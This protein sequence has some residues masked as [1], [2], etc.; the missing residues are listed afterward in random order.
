MAEET[1]HTN[2][3][4]PVLAVRVTKI[5]WILCII[6]TFLAWSV[7]GFTDHV[8]SIVVAR[9]EKL[10]EIVDHEMDD[11]NDNYEKSFNLLLQN[12]D[13]EALRNFKCFTGVK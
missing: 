12:K 7:L 11:T 4:E 10:L 1:I 9:A 5:L 6:N 2:G 3:N 13:S 8:E